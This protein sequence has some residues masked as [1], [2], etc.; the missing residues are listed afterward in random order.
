MRKIVWLFFVLSVL[1]ALVGCGNKSQEDV[2]NA[3][4]SKVEDMKGYK[5]EAKMTIQT[6]DEPQV[7]D[8]EIWHQKPDNYRVNL[9]NTERDQ[10]QMIL[11]NNEGVFVL[12]PAL[13]KSYRFQSDWPNNSSQPYLYESIVNDIMQD[14][15]ATFEAKDQLYV[16]E[17]KT[18]YQNHKMLPRQEITI[19]KKDLSP[20]VVKVMDPDYKPLITIEFGKMEFNPSFDED[21]FDTK[22]NMT[23]ARLDDLSI[24]SSTDL[25]LPVYYPSDQLVG[26]I[27]QE[28][29]T[30]ETENGKRIIMTYGGE[31]SYTLIQ[32]QAF[33]VPAMSSATIMN[34]DIVS[35]GDFT[36][37]ALT[38]NSLTWTYN[39]VDFML[40]SED[41]TQEE[42]I[43][44]ASSVKNQ[45][46][47]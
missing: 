17:T 26:V 42:M 6:G 47:K 14:T 38:N 39:G 35:L 41:L 40:A 30:V 11:R 27:P 21:A 10:S 36:I 37:G 7:Y 5:T 8:V 19:N 29:V 9:R 22:K 34:G 12:T 25:S 45:S 13:N 2:V 31:K 32:E 28:E 1:L 46:I 43:M 18:N 20:S 16:F 24:V 4:D 3:L 33:D 15:E 23:A 44:I